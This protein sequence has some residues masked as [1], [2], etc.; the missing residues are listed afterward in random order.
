[1]S[2]EHNQGK[3]QRYYHL[4]NSG[5]PIFSPPLEDP[6]PQKIADREAAQASQGEQNAIQRG[7][8]RTQKWIVALTLISGGAAW[9]GAW[10]SSRNADISQQAADT[11]DRSLL[12]AQKTERD[13]RA[14]SETG[15]R[16][17]RDQFRQDQRPY[18][19]QT[20]NSTSAPRTELT[21][22]NSAQIL[23][24][25]RV[26]NYGK[27]PA[28]DVIKREYIRLGNGSP[29]VGSFTNGRNI[30]DIPM[31]MAPTSEVLSTVIGREMTIDEANQL[32][33]TKE[34]TPISVKVVITYRDAYGTRYETGICLGYA[35]G[36]A[37]RFCEG[38]YIK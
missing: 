31:T 19:A 20:T 21:H 6:D 33:R 32:T 5:L 17:A 30:S 27:S 37:I 11:S 38:N 15:L 36:S 24:N 22:G 29:L 35:S 9:W 13:G 7:I 26:T 28:Y 16:Q 12:L 34:G 1:M 23:W 18:L 10:I 25:Y 2:D 8:L 3:Q 14:Q 4:D